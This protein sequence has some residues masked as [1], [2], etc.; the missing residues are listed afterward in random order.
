MLELGDAHSL[1]DLIEAAHSVEEKFG[2]KLWFRGHQEQNWQLIPSAYRKSYLLETQFV[3]HFRFRA[4]SLDLKCPKHEDLISWLPLMQHYGLPTRL[5][6]WSESLLIATFFALLNKSADSKPVIWI[7]APSNF[8]SL[9]SIGKFIPFLHN[10]RVKPIVQAAFDYSLSLQNLESMAVMAPRKDIR[11]TA[12]LCNFTIH[13]D[14]IPIEDYQNTN[15]FLARISIPSEFQN[16]IRQD[17]SVVGVR[18]SS[19][20]PDLTNLAHEISELVAFD[21]NGDIL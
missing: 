17:L 1:S 14:K 12:Q 4:P 19:V 18:R 9:S 5:L 20:F 21:E 8:N 16:K 11:M 6:D 7:F 15:N 13:G 3:N 2:E 10:E